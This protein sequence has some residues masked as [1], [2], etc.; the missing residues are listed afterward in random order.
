MADRLGPIGALA[1]IAVGLIAAR[2]GFAFADTGN[3]TASTVL[4]QQVG[5]R[6]SMSRVQVASV[7]ADEG[8]WVDSD[9]GRVWVQIDTRGESPYTVSRGEVVSFTGIVVAHGQDYPAQ[10]GV[11]RS[12]G[13]AALA[14]QGAHIRIPVN[15]IVF[16]H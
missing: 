10:V 13:A 8:F 15:G 6:V 2:G 4:S 7:P 16:D 1:A 9:H 14:A 5:Q 11:T 12:E 3:D